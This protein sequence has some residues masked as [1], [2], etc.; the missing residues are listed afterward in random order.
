MSKSVFEILFSNRSSVIGKTRTFQFFIIFACLFFSSINCRSNTMGDVRKAAYVKF[1]LGNE[2]LLDKAPELKDKRVGLLT[3]QTGILPDGTHIIDAMVSKGVNVV[4]I[5]SPEHGIRGDENYSEVDEK[6]GIQIVSLY[7]GKVK[8]SKSDMADI[9]I[10]IYDIQDVGARFYTY[11]STL[12]YAIEAAAESEKQIWVCDRPMI[13]EPGYTGGFM[14]EPG[15]ESFV[16]KIPVPQ[17]YGMTCGELASYL[18]SEVFGG[19]AKLDVL[20]MEGYTRNTEY[21][22]LKLTWVKPSPSMFY[23]STAVCYIANCLLEGTNVS[24]G[25][26]TERPFEYFGAPWVNSQVIADELNSQNF[27]GVKFEPL[28]FIPSEKISAYPP[29]FFNKECNGIFVNITDKN[30]FNAVKCGA[31]I[32]IALYKNCAEFKFNKD[33]FIDKL[34]GTDKLRKMIIA[35]NTADEIE[36]A[37]MGGLERFKETRSKY[38]LYK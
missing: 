25:R 34:A 23:P 24:E 14:L 15:Y 12:Y 28:T 37:W 13:T 31:A 33:N 1:R 6:T 2:V 18:N 7:N 32:L 36:A 20:M 26:G 10:M 9:D 8:P 3:N 29:K 21:S 38:L 27:E 5:F 22:S 17:A 19:S 4:K 16:G 30:K 11:T 35:G